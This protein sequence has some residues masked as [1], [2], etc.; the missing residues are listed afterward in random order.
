[1]HIF[2]ALVTA[3]ILSF[4]PLPI[5]LCV[6][7]RPHGLSS[8]QFVRFSGIVLVWLRLG[9]SCEWDFMQ[10]A[11]DWSSYRVS[12]Y[13]G[14]QSKKSTQQDKLSWL[15]SRKTPTKAPWSLRTASGRLLTASGRNDFKIHEEVSGN[16]HCFINYIVWK[17]ASLQWDR[18]KAKYSQSVLLAMMSSKAN[19]SKIVLNCVA[20]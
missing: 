17:L 18:V 5:I 3:P 19:C 8:V 11:S 6:E 7:L 13:V 16:N 14:E 2:G 10:I 20:K 4:P 1:M 15:S 9:Q 12:Q